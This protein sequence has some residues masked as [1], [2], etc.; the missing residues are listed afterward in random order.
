MHGLL[1]LQG[2]KTEG[3]RQQPEGKIP[4]KSWNEHQQNYLVKKNE[5][6]QQSQEKETTKVRERET[7]AVVQSQTRDKRDL[8]LKSPE[9]H[10][11]THRYVMMLRLPEN[12]LMQENTWSTLEKA[13]K[14]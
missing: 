9:M 8:L 12:L 1:E 5:G 11:N 13:E 4:G 6:W 2:R 7:I 10:R 14:K 3:K